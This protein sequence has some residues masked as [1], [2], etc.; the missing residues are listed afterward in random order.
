MRRTLSLSAV[1]LALVLLPAEQVAAAAPAPAAHVDPFE[2]TNRWMYAVSLGLDR[3]VLSPVVHVYTRVTPA[4]LRNRISAV[5]QNLGEPRTA[6]NEA[7]QGRPA[8][9]GRAV[10]RL[11]INTTVGLGGLFD[12]ASRV[13]VARSQADFGQ[14]L[15][16]YGVATGPYLFVPFLGPSNVRDG[17][18]HLIDSATD[19]VAWITGGLSSPFAARLVDGGVTVRLVDGGV[20]TLDARAQAEDAMHALDDAIDPYATIRSAYLQMREAAVDEARGQAPSLPDLDDPAP[21]ETAQR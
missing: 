11:A 15:G 20:T 19:P 2:R 3:A 4:V 8:P 14:T 17:L 5:I 16:R 6:I 18:G 21:T 13:G 9:A 1:G 12:V 10:A 7:L